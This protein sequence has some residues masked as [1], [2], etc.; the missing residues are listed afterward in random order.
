MP[1]LII[2]Y[3]LRKS[4]DYQKLYDA[5][6]SYGTYAKV[7]ESVWYVRSKTHT[8]TQC[9]DY[10]NQFID[11]DDRLGVFDCSN[12]DFATMRAINKISDLWEN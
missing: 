9:R 10:L 7:F 2:T 8:A 1:N 12:N 6:K 3:D 5:I 11:T 4:R